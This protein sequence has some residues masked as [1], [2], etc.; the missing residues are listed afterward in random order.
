MGKLLEFRA[1]DFHVDTA[2][3]NC[4]AERRIVTLLGQTTE[5]FIIGDWQWHWSQIYSDRTL[6]ANTDYVFRFAVRYGMCDTHDEVLRCIVVPAGKWDDRYVYDL[7]MSRYQP[8]HSKEIGADGGLLRIFEIPFSTGDCT[9]WKIMLVSAHCETWISPVPAE[10]AY[11][12]LPD[13]S[14][15]ELWQR[16]AKLEQT[17]D[18]GDFDDI[19]IGTGASVDLSGAVISARMLNQILRQVDA[20]AHID[21]SGAVIN[22]D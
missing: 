22:D 17:N 7:A 11:A 21:L 1:R 19:S 13:L 18:S 2:I 12:A 9:E 6:E 16:A 5:H 4:V 20:G 8:V 14:F 10:E 15:E 3:E